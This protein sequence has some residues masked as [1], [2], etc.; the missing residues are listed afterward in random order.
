[1]IGVIKVPDANWEALKRPIAAAIRA[2][3]GQ[4]DAPLGQ[5]VSIAGQPRSDAEILVAVQLVL[6]SQA[7]AF[8]LHIETYPA[9]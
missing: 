1:M 6:D 4:P 3:L 7:K 9:A 8:P 2:A 5:K